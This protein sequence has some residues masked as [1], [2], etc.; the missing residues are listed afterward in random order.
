[1]AWTAKVENRCIHKRSKVIHV[2]QGVRACVNC[3]WFEAHYRENRG[4]VKTFA[5]LPTGGCL[6]HDCQRGGAAAALPGL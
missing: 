5:Q 3:I 2:D 4:N 1:M 6:L